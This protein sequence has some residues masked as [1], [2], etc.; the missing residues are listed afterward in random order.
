MR[1]VKYNSLGVFLPESQWALNMALAVL[2][3]SPFDT[4]LH[5]QSEDWVP[6]LALTPT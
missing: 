3:L 2:S 6:L 1:D 5:Q 4:P